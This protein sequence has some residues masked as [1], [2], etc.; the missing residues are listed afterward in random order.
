MKLAVTGLENLVGDIISWGELMSGFEWLTAELV[1]TEAARARL[2]AWFLAGTPRRASGPS[3][4]QIAERLQFIG[5]AEIRRIVLDVLM[6]L[7]P[8]VVEHALRSAVFLGV[9]RESAGWITPLPIFASPETNRMMI[10]LNGQSDDLSLAKT[11]AHEIAHLW[12]E[13]I[14][15]AATV[16]PPAERMAPLQLAARLARE[17]N[18]PIPRMAFDRRTRSEVCAV[19]LMRSWGY[20]D[21]EQ[22]CAR[23]AVRSLV[24]HLED[25]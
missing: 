11:T 24:A 15:D 2:R 19:R 10:V 3:R 6:T 1:A 18:V 5:D 14:P 7:P 25:R 8:V 23:G 21:D 12:L 20:D 16:P 9:G 17:W 4:A 13:P 22:R